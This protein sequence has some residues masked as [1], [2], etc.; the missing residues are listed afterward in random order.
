MPLS[1]L[2]LITVIIL[3]LESVQKA[4][5]RTLKV[6]YLIKEIMLFLLV[7]SFVLGL[8]IRTIFCREEEFFDS[9]TDPFYVYN[10][11]TIGKTL[12]SSF[13]ISLDGGG[14]GDSMMKFYENDWL[15][16]TFWFFIFLIVKFF[17]PNVLVGAMT[18]E[19][20]GLY[21]NDIDYLT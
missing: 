4:I 10:F 1:D 8:L 3:T 12:W 20:M 7:F 16:F 15:K 14:T 21:Q 13:K 9:D 6:F 5:I 2:I 18:N 11:T 17:M 19:Y